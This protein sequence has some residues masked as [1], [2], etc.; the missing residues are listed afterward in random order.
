ME[1]RELLKS[2]SKTVISVLTTMPVTEAA[3]VMADQ[4][5]GF[6]V[7]KDEAGNLAGVLSERDILLS[8]TVDAENAS[9]RAVSGIMTKNVITCHVADNV[10]H[11][12]ELMGSHNIRHLVVM[13]NGN[14]AGVLSSRDVFAVMAD[15]IDEC[16]LVPID[17]DEGKAA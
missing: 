4:T 5:I 13:E 3:R 1:V 16:G 6:T 10:L 11:A 15:R 8:L 17:R 7:V 2:D 9:E 14:V 12:I